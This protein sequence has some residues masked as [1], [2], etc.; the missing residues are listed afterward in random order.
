MSEPVFYIFQV[1][2][3]YKCSIYL[4]FIHKI[5]YCSLVIGM[6]PPAAVHNQGIVHIAAG[7]DYLK[8]LL[9][10]EDRLPL[11]LH[12]QFVGVNGNHHFLELF[13]GPF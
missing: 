6:R 8:P 10:V 1:I 4:V 13:L 12:R 5:V 3:S 11:L 2:G 7:F 9:L